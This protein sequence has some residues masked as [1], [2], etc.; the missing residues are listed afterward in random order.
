[1]LEKCSFVKL[2]GENEA[3]KTK[4]AGCLKMYEL[5]YMYCRVNM[6]LSIEWK[7]TLVDE[8]FSSVPG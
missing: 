1:M 4:G 2:N 8:F 7:Y 6:C 3:L 5:N